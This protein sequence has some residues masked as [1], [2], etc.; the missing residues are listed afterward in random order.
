MFGSLLILLCL[1]LVDSSNIRSSVFKPM[2]K[3]VFWFLLIITITLGFIG[4][5][6]PVTPFI[7]IGQI[8]TAL[9]FAYFLILIPGVVL[10]EK[11]LLL[12]NF[13]NNNINSLNIPLSS[14]SFKS[15]TIDYSPSYLYLALTL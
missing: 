13:S 8:A 1:P 15:I 14:V 12:I 11:I 6:H 3:L 9:Y 5:Q 10:I 2:S 7:E 4:S